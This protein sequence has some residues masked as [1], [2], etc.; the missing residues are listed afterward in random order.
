M[1]FKPNEPRGSIYWGADT[2][3]IDYSPDVDVTIS[4]DYLTLSQLGATIFA[5][6]ARLP[7][8]NDAYAGR[9][10]TYNDD[11]RQRM[12]NLGLE[13]MGAYPLHFDVVYDAT[14][15][16]GAYWEHDTA[17]KG[18]WIL[19]LLPSTPWSTYDDIIV[20]KT[21]VVDALPYNDH[22]NFAEFSRWQQYFPYPEINVDQNVLYVGI[23][24]KFSKGF[25]GVVIQYQQLVTGE[26]Q[27]RVSINSDN[28]N[29]DDIEWSDW[30]TITT[31]DP[32][33]VGVAGPKGDK[34]DTG[35]TGPQGIQG[36]QG[37][38]GPQGE[39]G[40]Q[41]ISGANANIPSPTD[42]TNDLR[43]AIS[44]ACA[45]NLHNRWDYGIDNVTTMTEEL[46]TGG[47]VIGA[48]VAV[49]FPEVALAIALAAGFAEII[50]QFG[51][52][53]SAGVKANF[54][55]DF[56]HDAAEALY[57][58]MDDS[59][60]ITNEVLAAWS[61]GVA[62]ISS[63]ASSYVAAII[64]HSPLDHWRSI[65]NTAALLNPAACTDFSCEPL[66]DVIA[67][68]DE[69]LGGTGTSITLISGT[70]YHIVAPTIDIG[71]PG[72]PNH[73]S[74]LKFVDPVTSDPVLCI[75]SVAN[76]TDFVYHDSDIN[77]GQVDQVPLGGEHSSIQY[78]GTQDPVEWI[79]MLT[80]ACTRLVIASFQVFEY[81]LT[82]T[83]AP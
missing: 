18:H 81:D 52:A 13:L 65:A 3:P 73:R 8:V 67:V 54:D 4:S 19:H 46:N 15:E 39:Q 30:Q 64:S 22:N 63:D 11:L 25:T 83:P 38:I 33:G 50:T 77:P 41:G 14:I 61:S 51:L 53:L 7:T 55:E 2:D 59:C 45:K 10:F 21:S 49:I 16:T 12:I 1:I 76:F 32:S 5:E 27:S 20:D 66:P 69:S 72:H 62:G 29:T 60:N 26:L 31:I 44:W 75:L 43:C 47:L 40:P 57:C 74:A 34:G 6:A 68:V 56:E 42:P 79:S 82:I 23:P 48:I 70:T 17:D 28:P 36:I 80:F 24:D 37:E 78:S 71:A 35:D 9:T 58:A